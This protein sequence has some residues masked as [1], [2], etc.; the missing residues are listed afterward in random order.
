VL[1]RSP[2]PVAAPSNRWISPR[3]STCAFMNWTD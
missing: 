1:D 3:R 2:F